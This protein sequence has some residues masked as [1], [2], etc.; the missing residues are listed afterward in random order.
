MFIFNAHILKL[1]LD[2]N[3]EETD[4]FLASEKKQHI[5]SPIYISN[6]HWLFR[7]E[8]KFSSRISAT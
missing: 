6:S 3:T 8:E 5:F 4:I 1:K 7:I 2:E